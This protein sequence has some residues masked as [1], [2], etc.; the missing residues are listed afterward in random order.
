MA[1][2]ER[3]AWSG[4]SRE[5]TVPLLQRGEWTVAQV[6]TPDVKNGSPAV[7]LV[8]S[9]VNRGLDTRVHNSE[10]APREGGAS[11]ACRPELGLQLAG[12]ELAITQSAQSFFICS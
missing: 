2:H 5:A 7:C 11:M 12:V 1:A 10:V 4:A 3:E 6:G 9:L 8:R